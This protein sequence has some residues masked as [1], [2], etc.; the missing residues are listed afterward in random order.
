[1]AAHDVTDRERHVR[2][3]LEHAGPGRIARHSLGHTL[4]IYGWVFVASVAIGYLMARTDAAQFVRSLR[5]HPLAELIAATAFGLIPNCAASVAIA[6]GYVGGVL[7]SGATFAGLAAGAGYGPILLVRDGA[8]GR[9]GA[10]LGFCFAVAVASGL[11]VNA[12]LGG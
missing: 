11:L 3:E 2:A 6:E 8:L 7:T 12:V 10:L 4:E 5:L 9:A 1:V